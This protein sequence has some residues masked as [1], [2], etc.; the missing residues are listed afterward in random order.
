MAERPPPRKARQIFETSFVSEMNGRAYHQ[1]MR[2]RKQPEHMQFTHNT[3]TWMERNDLL[4]RFRLAFRT[5]NSVLTDGASPGRFCSLVDGGRFLA[6]PS[7]AGSH[8]IDADLAAV[9]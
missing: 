7:G 8:E 4:G 5:Y 1:T 9:H 3:N 2:L 6:S